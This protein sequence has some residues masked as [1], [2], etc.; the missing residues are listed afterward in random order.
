MMSTRAIKENR[1]TLLPV[2]VEL[3]GYI[4]KTSHFPDSI[5]IARVKPL[6]KKWCK[7]DMT[8]YRPISILNIN[9]KLY[10]QDCGKSV[11]QLDSGAP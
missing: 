11:A 1:S 7:Y 9:F 3:V 4:I 5:K 2:L 10:I 6:F 8:I